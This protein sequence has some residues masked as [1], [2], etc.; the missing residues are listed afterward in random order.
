MKDFQ[1]NQHYSKW[2][3]VVCESMDLNFTFDANLYLNLVLSNKKGQ[4]FKLYYQPV[5]ILSQVSSNIFGLNSE[6]TFISCCSNSEDNIRTFTTKSRKSLKVKC[7]CKNIEVTAT[8][9]RNDKSTVV[10]ANT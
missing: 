7:C 9:I 10:G 4:T 8:Y 5:L 1:L 3:K 2:K 6:K